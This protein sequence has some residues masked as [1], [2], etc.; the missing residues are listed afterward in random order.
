M[1]FRFFSIK[2]FL[3]IGLI[4]VSLIWGVIFFLVWK[5]PTTYHLYVPHLTINRPLA[6]Q[7][8][9]KTDFSQA[10]PW[11]S[12]LFMASGESSDQILGKSFL[13]HGIATSSA[14]VRGNQLIS[15]FN[16]YPQ[17]NEQ[18]LGRVF[19]MSSSDNGSHWSRPEQVIFFNMPSIEKAPQRPVTILMPNGN[20][21]MFFIAK[22]AGDSNSKLFAAVSKDG[23]N[24][25]FDPKTVFEIEN[26]SLISFGAAMD[27]G[28]LHLIAYTQEGQKTGNSYHAI[29]YDGQIFTRLADIKI[30]DSYYGQGYLF[31]DQDKLVLYGN[32]D[33][34]LWL[35]TSDDGNSWSSPNYLGVSGQ[36][37]VVVKNKRR[38]P[39]F[40]VR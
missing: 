19:T 14:V 8:Q 12:D 24:F 34:G 33:K 35:S 36:N 21:K 4:W 1:G 6:V 40:H 15:Y 29:S 37:P 7:N 20:L 25:T 23:I 9:P 17:E 10:G 2:T 5:E 18:A 38:L 28:K 13:N 39:F 30:Q 27:D 3:L 31:S 16:Y 22:K 32:S 26:E 11:K